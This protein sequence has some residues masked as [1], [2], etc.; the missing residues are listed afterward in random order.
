MP[1]KDRTAEFFEKVNG[2]RERRLSAAAAPLA[3][4]GGRLAPT[5]GRRFGTRSKFAEDAATI[6]R[7]FHET[8]AKLEKLT[9]RTERHAMSEVGR[10]DAGRKD[11]LGERTAWAKGRPG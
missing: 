8:A 11:G 2:E 6:M 10:K 7:Q 4:A 3:A 9:K 1:G 5:R